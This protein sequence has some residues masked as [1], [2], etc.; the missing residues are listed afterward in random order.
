MSSFWLV[1]VLSGTP[2]YSKEHFHI[3][4]K[5][6]WHGNPKYFFSDAQ[7]FEMCSPSPA[8]LLEMRYFAL[9]FVWHFQSFVCPSPCFLP[10]I[11]TISIKVQLK[12][13]IYWS[14]YHYQV[15]FW[16]RSSGSL[17]FSKYQ[18]IGFRLLRNLTSF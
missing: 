8:L 16:E 7:L 9:E 17:I 5:E 1:N 15:F 2:L 14:F 4:G 3:S 18:S 13:T 10:L 11:L 12:I 6:F